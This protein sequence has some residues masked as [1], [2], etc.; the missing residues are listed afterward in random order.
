LYWTRINLVNLTIALIV[1]C[2]LGYAVYRGLTAIGA[3]L[4][5]TSMGQVQRIVVKGTD[6]IPP[7]KI[8]AAAR[9][10]KGLGIY[11]IPTDSVEARVRKL[12]GIRKAHAAGRLF[13]KMVVK[14]EE[15]QPL[16][17]V[18]A[19]TVKL[20]D[21]DGVIFPKETLRET[22]DYPLL[23]FQGSVHNDSSV[24]AA[25]KYMEMLFEDYTE[26]YNQLSELLIGEKDYNLRLRRGGGKVLA[27]NVAD[28]Q[29]LSE[30]NQFLMQK[31]EYL[32]T[33]I[34]YVDMRFPRR[35][36]VKSGESQP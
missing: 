1:L 28:R 29:V 30:L 16:A 26:V 2:G 22:I 20:I 9:I 18:I 21:R 35:I 6:R 12:P 15:R 33:D 17:S 32:P 31:R 5:T 24:S 19:S 10:T 11:H 27:V 14:V 13:G 23:N 34:E 36:Y 4:E 25:L 8:A 7:E 3:W